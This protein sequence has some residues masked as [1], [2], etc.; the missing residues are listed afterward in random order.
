MP[1]SSFFLA[2]FPLLLLL[3]PLTTAD[4]CNADNCLRALLA[5][6]IT[7]S[8]LSFCNSYTV[9]LSGTAAPTPTFVPT[10]CSPQR[11]SSA[12]YCA[13]NVANPTF[14]PAA[15]PT[16][17]QILQN[18]S[19][20]GRAFQLG[21]RDVDIRP[22]VLA[23]PNGTPGCVPAG[24]YE[25]ADM[26][27]IWGDP[28]SIECSFDPA[29][30][31]LSTITQDIQLCPSTKYTL[32]IAT[33]CDFWTGHG[34]FGIQFQVSISGSVILPWGPV[35]PVCQASDSPFGDDDCRSFAVYEEQSAVFTSPSSGKGSLV[36]SVRQAAGLN[37]TQ[38]PALFD[39]IFLNPIGDT[40]EL[41]PSNPF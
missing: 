2:L 21:S 37:A 29:I 40:S 38:V 13:D 26:D 3:L 11:V 15:C 32:R 41:D 24:T 39:Q 7:S 36:I 6:E 14:T 4:T 27:G 22:W 8:A 10:S 16:S 19:F 20:Y 18:P 17:G 33:A 35:C 12:C 23:V 30:G 28:K 9:G 1:P 34:D 31:G 5:P 25:T